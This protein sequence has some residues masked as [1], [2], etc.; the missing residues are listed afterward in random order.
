MGGKPGHGLFDAERPEEVNQ[1]IEKAERDRRDKN[2][3]FSE[4]EMTK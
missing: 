3:E 4:K 2:I 1:I